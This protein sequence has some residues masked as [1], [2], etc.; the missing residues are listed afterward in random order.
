MK[1]SDSQNFNTNTSKL[2][3][4]P[5]IL[6]SFLIFALYLLFSINLTSAGIPKNSV[7]I[8]I[9]DELS[10]EMPVKA[11]LEIE[12]EE[13]EMTIQQK[14]DSL[15]FLQF[16]I[17]SMLRPEKEVD[18]IEFDTSLIFFQILLQKAEKIK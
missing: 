3:F 5:G 16:D 9:S 10:V 18:D 1:T 8:R 7:S 6:M 4:H 12:A 2:L 17:S 15:C 11:D 14:K 13:Y